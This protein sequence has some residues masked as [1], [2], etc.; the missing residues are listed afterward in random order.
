MYR[1]LF[2]GLAP[3]VLMTAV[4]LIS[5][6]NAATASNAPAAPTATPAPLAENLTFHGDIKGTLTAGINVL[7]FTHDNPVGST[8][9]PRSTQCATFDSND[10]GTIDD[11]LA[12]IVGIVGG[13]EYSVAI[14]V[15]ML[16]NPAYTHP[17]TPEVLPNN[18][19]GSVTVY[20]LGGQNREWDVVLGPAL[21]F[22]NVVLH[23]DRKSGTVDAWLVWPNGQSLS[24]L[25]GTLH[26]QGD[27][28]C[29]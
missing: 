15:S 6:C 26:L 23:A 4:V 21:Q 28:R 22:S 13:K 9:V 24:G 10:T 8:F 2:R 12:T 7:P 11:S 17:G 5:G 18:I 25:N 3:L 14:E 29:G 19:V 1:L 16:D 20:E 27:W